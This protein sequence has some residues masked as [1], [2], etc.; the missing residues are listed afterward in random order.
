[1][2]VSNEL[3]PGLGFGFW[4]KNLIETNSSARLTKA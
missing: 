4:K 2:I 3:A 1:M